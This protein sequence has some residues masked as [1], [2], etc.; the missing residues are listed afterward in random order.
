MRLNA[1]Q[2]MRL[3]VG[4]DEYRVLK[5]A[6]ALLGAENERPLMIQSESSYGLLAEPDEYFHFMHNFGYDVRSAN[7][8]PSAKQPPDFS[9]LFT[10]S[11]AS[12]TVDVIF[13]R[14]ALRPYYARSAMSRT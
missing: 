2:V 10:K 9:T 7:G 14:P 13:D 8:S 12:A 11:A 1:S 3:D 6:T 4:G 5:G